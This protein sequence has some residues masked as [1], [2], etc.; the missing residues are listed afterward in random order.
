MFIGL[1]FIYQPIF[2]QCSP[3]LGWLENGAPRWLLWHE[4]VGGKV[5]RFEWPTKQNQLNYSTFADLVSNFIAMQTH[6]QPHDDSTPIRASNALPGGRAADTPVHTTSHLFGQLEDLAQK[7]SRKDK[8]TS[9]HSADLSWN[10]NWVVIV[11]VASISLHWKKPSIDLTRI[12]LIS[13]LVQLACFI[14]IVWLQFIEL[15]EL[16][17]PK[18]SFFR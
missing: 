18:K 14:L 17:A 5:L 7:K 8:T 10:R 4:Y 6:L 13:W 15:V 1:G 3:F 9:H 2:S 12:S 11:L 16:A